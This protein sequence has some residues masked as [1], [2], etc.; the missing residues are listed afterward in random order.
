VA[1]RY[2]RELF[3]HSRQQGA[4]RIRDL[5]ITVPVGSFDTYRA[6]LRGITDWLGVEKL[7]FLDEPVA[8]AIGYGVSLDRPR[9]VLVFDMGGGTW[10]LARVQIHP[11]GVEAGRSEVQSKQGGDIGGDRVDSWLVEEL[12][13][14][15]G[16]PAPQPGPDETE[17]LWERLVRA[18]ARKVKEALHFEAE[19][20]FTLV[21]PEELRGLR[22]RLQRGPSSLRLGRDRLTGLLER[23]GL[24][25]TL[26]QALDALVDPDSIEEVLLVGGSTL[27]PGLYP[28]FE[29]RFGRDRV[30]AWQPFESVVLGAASYAGQGFVSSDLIVH[31]YAIEVW[32]SHGQKAEYAVVIPRGTRFPTPPDLWQQQLVPTCALAEPERIFKLI[33]YEIGARTGGF[34]WDGA[35]QLHS[36]SSEREALRVPL[37]AN[38]PALGHLDP[39]H[40]PEDRR[41]RLQVGFGVNA[42]RWLVA[43]VRDLKTGRLL[44]DAEPVVRLL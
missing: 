18:E 36:P 38:S 44:K 30:R 13:A 40:P 35:G 11:R 1:R 37:N 17:R 39:P 15:M 43:T 2:L 16:L 21:A 20:D 5:V 6:E 41:P 42:E 33:I 4:D 23:R 7:R 27:L 19:A 10:H 12:C 28:L 32:D 34:A 22:S 25:P 9:Q 31:D 3:A 14:E 24:M 29:S 26:R 8:A